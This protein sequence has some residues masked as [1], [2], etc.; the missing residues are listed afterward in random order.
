MYANIPGLKKKCP[1]RCIILLKREPF[2]MNDPPLLPNPLN[3]ELSF[4]TYLFVTR[5]RALPKFSMELKV[6]ILELPATNE[7][8]VRKV[9]PF[10]YQPLYFVAFVILHIIIFL[11]ADVV[12]YSE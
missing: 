12:N 6:L 4:M 3:I 11:V 1:L 5:K 2:D 7:S 9:V 8:Q 10:L